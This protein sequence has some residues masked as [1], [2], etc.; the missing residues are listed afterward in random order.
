MPHYDLL[1]VPTWVFHPTPGVT[2]TVAL[3]NEGPNPLYV[4]QQYVTPF[5]GM[6]LLPGCRITLTRVTS[7]VY[8]CSPVNLQSQATTISASSTP[9]STTFTVGS[10]SAFGVGTVF[11][12]GSVPS[13]CETFIV[14]S[15]TS[16]TVITT[17]TA[18]LYRH[19]TGSP[20]TISSFVSAQLGVT[21]GAT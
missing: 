14:A 18:A 17:T 1:P 10:N 13:D 3:R 5:N 19:V 7:D 11:T 12:V 8:A 4:G 16:T 20:L 21:Q 6:V 2:A 9:G 15:T